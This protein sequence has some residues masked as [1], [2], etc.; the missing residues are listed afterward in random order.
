MY[1]APEVP[2]GFDHGAPCAMTNQLG[3]IVHK[4]LFS[5]CLNIQRIVRL[6]QY[7]AMTRDR[8][9]LTG[10]QPRVF[11]SMRRLKCRSADYCASE[12][13]SSSAAVDITDSDHLVFVAVG[14]INLGDGAPMQSS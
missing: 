8:A 12:K 9:C 7:V 5:V 11:A 14:S 10:T 1:F 6:I 3:R 2:F 4:S 13:I